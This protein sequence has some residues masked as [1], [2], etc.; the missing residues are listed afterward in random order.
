M[1][2]ARGALAA[3][4][5]AA[6]GATAAREA[7]AQ[8]AIRHPHDRDDYHVELEPNFQLGVIN[9]PGVATGI[10]FGAG[11]RASF[12]IVRTGFV[13][14]I[15]NSIAIGVGTDYLHYP[16]SG[17]VSPGTCTRF[18]T[19]PGGTRVCTQVSQVGG[20]SDYLY[21]PL[22]MQWNFW[23]TRRWSVFGEPG[24]AVYWFDNRGAG[25]IPVLYL[26]GRFRINSRLGVTMRLGYPTFSVGLS[27]MF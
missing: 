14:T 5:I 21:F 12:E 27:I 13:P 8:L 19:G 23:L 17:V 15:N 6:A 16:G 26:G 9:P 1:L 24:L 25:V 2:R 20:P 3:I 11:F 4:A 7:S 18:V 22:V 10:G